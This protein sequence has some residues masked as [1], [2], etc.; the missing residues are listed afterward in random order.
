MSFGSVA[1]CV[2][3]GG[4][5]SLTKGAS[6]SIVACRYNYNVLR[7]IMTCFFHETALCCSTLRN[8]WTAS[9]WLGFVGMFK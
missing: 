9:L 5:T 2:N 3:V 1:L 4:N 6:E 8:F 7:K